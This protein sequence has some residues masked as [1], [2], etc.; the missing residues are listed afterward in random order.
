MGK[1]RR[2]TESFSF[3]GR[4]L[5]RFPITENEDNAMKTLFH[6]NLFYSLKSCQG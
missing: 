4:F 6:G 3:L 2:N 1:E 5:L